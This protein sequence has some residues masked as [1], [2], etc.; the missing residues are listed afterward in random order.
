MRSVTPV[1][2]LVRKAL[3]CA[4]AAVLAHPSPSYAWD[5]AVAGKIVGVD[6]TAG[7][8]YDLRIYLDSGAMCGNANAWAYVNKSNPN[9]EAYVC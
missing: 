3:A 9:Y 8:N 1:V 4:A 5:G 2:G 7:E 6:V